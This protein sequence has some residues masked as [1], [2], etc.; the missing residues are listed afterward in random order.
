M[1]SGWLVLCFC[2]YYL[3]LPSAALTIPLYRARALTG[4]RR[5]LPN[6]VPAFYI[7]IYMKESL[8][9]LGS[10]LLQHRKCNLNAKKLCGIQ[11]AHRC[12]SGIVSAKVGHFEGTT[13]NI[14]LNVFFLF[15]F[16]TFLFCFALF[17]GKVL[18]EIS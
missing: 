12:P 3:H 2:N 9:L 7:Y 14:S 1:G 18:P 8:R 13:S 17:L 15:Y 16:F 10:F 11:G 4:E 6:I 5:R